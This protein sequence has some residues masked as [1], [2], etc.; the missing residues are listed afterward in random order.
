MIAS[1]FSWMAHAPLRFPQ[2]RLALLVFILLVLLLV[3]LVLPQLALACG[4]TTG[5]CHCPGC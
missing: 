4:Q 1:I 5:S 2:R 3:A